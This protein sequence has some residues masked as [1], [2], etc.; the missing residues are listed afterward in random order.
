MTQAPLHLSHGGV[1]VLIAPDQFGVPTILHWGSALGDL[2]DADLAT[3]VAVTEP[4]VS[5]S[6]VDHPRR[7]GLVPDSARGF[8]GTPG[9]AGL[10]TTD[11]GGLSAI[12]PSILD[13]TY[14]LDNSDPEESRVRLSGTD[15][16]AGWRVGIELGLT[17]AGLL[18]MRTTVTNVAAG[19]LHLAS[20]ANV[21]PVGPHATELLDLTGRWCKERAP[22]RHP[23]VQ[24]S[25][26]RAGRHGRTG[27]D[28][29]LLMVAGTPGFGFRHGELWGVHT[30]WS[31]DH[32]TYAERTAE[33]EC[34]LGG[35]ELLAPGEV[36][37]RP[38]ENY[39]SPWLLGSYSATG[40]DGVSARL[41]AWLRQQ[42]PRARSVRKVVVNTWEAVYFDHDLERLT[43]LA[44]RA[45]Q[46]GA[47]RF[48]L[49]DGWFPGRVTDRVGLG[50]WTVDPQRWPNGLHPLIDAVKSRGLDF[51]LWVEPEMINVDSDVAR[52]HPEWILKGREALPITWRHQQVIDLQQPEAYAYIRDAM[53][54]LLEEYD[55]AYFKWD[56][57]RDLID[58]SHGG[59]PAVHGQTLALY[60]LMDEIRAAHPDVEIESCA[61]GGAR[62][63]AE[64]LRRTDRI[65]PSDTIDAVERQTLQRWTSLLVPPELI[66]SH[67]G[68]PTAHTTGRAHHL[69]FR[70]A[71]GMLFHF[72]I[73]WDL[74]TLSAEQLDAV[75]RWVTLHKRIRPLISDG[76]TV[77]GDHPDPNILV[78]GVVAPDQSEAWYVVAAVAA[79]DTQHPAPIRL[80]GL[81]AE[82]RYVLSDETPTDDQHDMGFGGTWRAESG[83]AT[84]GSVLGL[85]GVRLAPTAPDSARVWRVVAQ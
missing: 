52:A 16:E 14:D 69:G 15:S 20:V 70:A 55:I 25:F 76:V 51:G 50:D 3:L 37:L 68:G 43:L 49:D 7:T 40:L 46:V 47:E 13:W 80:P 60:R 77:R 63:D 24:G 66:G 62:V 4:G 30:A 9:L 36:V 35:G 54:A 32:T 38:D 64:I 23:W 58:V 45:A 48:V 27:H 44:D 42:T 31:G 10:R 28:A 83:L 67:L 72:G 59:R 39:R 8:T 11:D 56:H 71:T 61:S 65:W 19:A 17:V 26:V 33:G 57:N 12:M 78:Q 6:A 41:H 2:T 18:R 21:L 34:L 74:T 75:G 81:A 53:L 79:T 82:R 5:H 29:T 1:S 85:A 22:Q 73:E 84:A